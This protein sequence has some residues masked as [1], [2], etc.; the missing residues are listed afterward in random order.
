MKCDKNVQQKLFFTLSLLPAIFFELPIT[1]TFFNFP[2]RFELSKVDCIYFEFVKVCW[3]SFIGWLYL[4]LCYFYDPSMF[5]YRWNSNF[6]QKLVL[7]REHG[8]RDTW[9]MVPS[10]LRIIS[11][12][13]RCINLSK[14]SRKFVRELRITTT[15][16]KVSFIDLYLVFPTT[17]R[18]VFLPHTNTV[19]LLEPY[20]GTVTEPGL[21][22]V[23]IMSWKMPWKKISLSAYSKAISHYFGFNG[24]IETSRT[25]FDR[26]LRNQPRPT[27][28]RI[29]I[30]RTVDF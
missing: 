20:R 16:Y 9:H 19:I 24:P 7:E 29:G 21:P 4:M 6:E 27:L 3:E 30:W 13:G 2:W 14:L 17:F 26:E 10:T 5:I 11:L 15:N 23:I 1:R 8:G 18:I 12:Y 22:V 28:E 25:E